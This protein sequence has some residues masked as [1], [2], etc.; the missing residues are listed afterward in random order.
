[1]ATRRGSPGRRGPQAARRSARVLLIAII[2]AIGLAGIG[3]ATMIWL[4]ARPAQI[5]TAPSST[6]TAGTTEVPPVMT[7]PG[8]TVAPGDVAE[9]R[10]RVGQLEHQWSQ[11]HAG[12]RLAA[13]ER[14]VDRLPAED[15]PATMVLFGLFGLWLLLAIALGVVAAMLFRRVDQVEG[16]VDSPAPVSTDASEPD[17]AIVRLERRIAELETE[18]QTA[19]PAPPPA[20]MPIV[21][22]PP[23]A[24]V[25]PSGSLDDVAEELRQLVNARGE[26]E[27]FNAAV[28][29]QPRAFAVID[30][31][32]VPFDASAA[33]DQ[34]LVLFG[35]DDRLA[36]LPAPLRARDLQR[37][38]NV[39]GALPDSIARVFTI[40]PGDGFRVTAPAFVAYAG[41]EL[42]LIARGAIA[43]S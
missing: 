7:S 26:L 34:E 5:T 30:G 18:R 31:A 36:V 17:P 13:L 25:E 35:D 33:M 24:A 14:T 29:A 15:G 28:V 22:A 1:M 10:G 16:Q 32:V 40:E 20:P 2:V 6:P 19:P 4:H 21:A 8:A 39:R 12:E 23:P 9:L 11:A 37:S 38:P 27:T 42:R 3:V 41:G 43:A